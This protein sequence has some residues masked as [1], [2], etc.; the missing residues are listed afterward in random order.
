MENGA[1]DMILPRV[2]S[3]VF[4]RGM[5]EGVWRDT[6]ENQYDKCFYTKLEIATHISERTFT[7]GGISGDSKKEYLAKLQ[8]YAIFTHLQII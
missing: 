8:Y 2:A 5:N 1:L 7:W 6:G 3:R 4:V